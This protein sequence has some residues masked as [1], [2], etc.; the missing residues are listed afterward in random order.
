MNSASVP[1]IFGTI[2]NNNSGRQVLLVGLIVFLT[3]LLFHNFI[4]ASE[5]KSIKQ[6]ES[7]I[8][9][10]ENGISTFSDLSLRSK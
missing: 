10:I 1:D 9:Q 8:Q 3:V 7:Q 6:L 2:L 5:L 4:L